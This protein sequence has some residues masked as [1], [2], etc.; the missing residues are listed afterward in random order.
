MSLHI[1]DGLGGVSLVVCF[2]CGEEL[3]GYFIYYHMASHEE[4]GVIVRLGRG[5]KERRARDIRGAV[6]YQEWRWSEWVERLPD[7]SRTPDAVGDGTD[8]EGL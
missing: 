6:I 3:P 4:E 2:V 8:P 5:P 1:M 7:D